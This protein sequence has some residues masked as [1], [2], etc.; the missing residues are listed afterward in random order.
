MMTNRTKLAMQPGQTVQNI[1]FRRVWEKMSL[2]RHKGTLRPNS[3]I[4]HPLL[5]AASGV[6]GVDLCQEQICQQGRAS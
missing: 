5:L 1:C 3:P 4:L 6:S 2:L